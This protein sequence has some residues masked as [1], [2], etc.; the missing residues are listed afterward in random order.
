MLPN[1]ALSTTLEYSQFLPPDNL[2][3]S[4][5]VDYEEGGVALSDGSQGLQVQVWTLQ[6]IPTGGLSDPVDVVISAPNTEAT[7]LFSRVGIS[8]VALAFDQ[9]MHPFV[10]FVQ[11]GQATFWWFDTTVLQFV[12]TDLPTGS[13]DTCCCIDDRRSLQTL[14]GFNDIILAYIR[15]DNLYYRQQRD[16]YTTEYLLVGDLSTIVINP[17]LAKVAMNGKSRLQFFLKGNLYA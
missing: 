17:Q 15:D 2:P 8:K 3:P 7:T 4:D 10:A 9:N 6:G 13:T 12:F 5:M 16:R 1:N 11:N 14:T